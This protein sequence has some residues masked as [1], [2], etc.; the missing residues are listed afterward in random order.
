MSQPRPPVPARLRSIAHAHPRAALALYIAGGLLLAPYLLTLVY[1]IVPAPSTLMVWRL[2]SFQSVSRQWV[3]LERI[4]PHL[5]RAVVAS[6][7]DGFCT[8]AG[9]SF[10]AISAA[11]RKAERTGKPV[12]GTSTITMQAAKNLYLW[13]G[14]SYMRKVLEAPQ[15]LWLDLVLTKRR[16]LE[17]YLNIA[18]WGPGIF[19]A[20][21]AARHH[22]GIPASALSR[23]QAALLATSLPNP[24]RRVAGKPGPRQRHLAGLL[25]RRMGNTELSCLSR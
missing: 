20:E 9:I 22:F 5:Q 23:E 3:P 10:A 7:D 17:L 8:H 24:A 4:S 11:W 25:L 6:E 19:G 18:E 14:R 16:V 15:A 13:H 21:A 2:A 1:M 12:Q